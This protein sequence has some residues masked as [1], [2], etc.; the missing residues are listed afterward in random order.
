VIGV[1][2]LAIVVAYL[3]IG[4]CAANA[5]VKVYKIGEDG[6]GDVKLSQAIYVSLSF[7]F[8]PIMLPALWSIESIINDY[9]AVS[10]KV[11]VWKTVRPDGSVT[12]AI[13]CDR[14]DHEAR[15]KLN[16]STTDSFIGPPLYTSAI[17]KPLF[18]HVKVDE[19]GR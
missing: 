1:T 10:T 6:F 4:L 12:V 7:L 14:T 5:I 3:G 13:A 16:A 17:A 18:V 8:W 11:F 9:D 19:G 2:V 15:L